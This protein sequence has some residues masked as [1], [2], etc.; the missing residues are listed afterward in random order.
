MA[1]VLLDFVVSLL[2]SLISSSSL[3]SSLIYQPY[4]S[5]TQAISI[6]QLSQLLTLA[7]AA[8][9]LAKV[10]DD[11]SPIPASVPSPSDA[12][13]VTADTFGTAAGAV[14]AR[15]HAKDLV[16][17]MAFSILV[18]EHSNFNGA[19]LTITGI[20]HGVCYNINSGWNDRIS[21]TDTRGH[22]CT[23]FQHAS[24]RGDQSTVNG[25]VNWGHMNDQISSY[26]CF[27]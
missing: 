11:N 4:A 10:H 6:M 27:E 12:V 9:V 22:T 3:S 5:F 19:C 15:L 25:R 8:V 18:C 17:R 1:V 2:C 20:D 21:S 13:T 23:V 7:S 24:C 26:R 14:S 16:E